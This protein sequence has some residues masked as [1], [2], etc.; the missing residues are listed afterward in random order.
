MLIILPDINVKVVLLTVNN[1]QLSK[2]IRVIIANYV[3]LNSTVIME[4]VLVNAVK[5]IPSQIIIRCN[6]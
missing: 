4:I 2:L 6:V 1:A 3:T 5:T